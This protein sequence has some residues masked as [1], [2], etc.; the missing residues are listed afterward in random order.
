[1]D[2]ISVTPIPAPSFVAAIGVTNAISL[3]WYAV[4][5]VKYQVQYTT[6]LAGTNWVNMSTNAATSSTLSLT[7]HPGSDRQRF[8]RILRLP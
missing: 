6:N 2:D 4:P 7:N 1:L 3:T 8:Y 5:G